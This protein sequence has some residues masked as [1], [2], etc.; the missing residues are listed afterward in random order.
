M[1]GKWSFHLITCAV[2]ILYFC[3]FLQQAFAMS[4]WLPGE[5]YDV[6]QPR[7]MQSEYTGKGK[8]VAFDVAETGQCFVMIEDYLDWYVNFYS[9]DGAFLRCLYYYWDEGTC[10]AFYEDAEHLSILPVRSNVIICLDTTDGSF[11]RSYEDEGWKTEDSLEDFNEDMVI[12]SYEKVVGQKRYVLTIPGSFQRIVKGVP[13][14]LTITDADG[15]ERI[16][17][18]QNTFSMRAERNT[19]IRIVA[20]V[21]FIT[22]I[23]I[24]LTRYGVIGSNKHQAGS[25]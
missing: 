25:R 12:A 1:K 15:K 23:L 9:K 14:T 2:C 7:F 10:K 22:G 20:T 8:I 11:Y 13:R 3:L 17:Y 24:L 5:I 18:Q 21:V 19:A 16:A 6:M 4:L